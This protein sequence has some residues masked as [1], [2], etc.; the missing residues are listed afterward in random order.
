MPTPYTFNKSTNGFIDQF[1]FHY[2]DNR[3]DLMNKLQQNAIQISRH[4]SE[5]RKTNVASFSSSKSTSISNENNNPLNIIVMDGGGMRGRSNVKNAMN[6]VS[7]IHC[8]QQ[9]NIECISDLLD[10]LH[11]TSGLLVSPQT[12][13]L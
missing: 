13:F 8:H 1:V 5:E 10:I 11:N 2:N 9:R 4:I 3:E 6:D 12:T 7:I